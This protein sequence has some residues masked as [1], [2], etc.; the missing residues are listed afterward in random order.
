MKDGDEDMD[1]LDEAIGT[2]GEHFE[3][4]QIFVTRNADDNEGTVNATK[5]TGNW[6]TRYGQV[7]C[8]LIKEDE[9]SRISM[10]KD[11]EET[12]D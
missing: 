1:R 7:R 12:G 4:V 2:L 11:Y 5:G 9:R 6:F 3:S 8:W 10:R